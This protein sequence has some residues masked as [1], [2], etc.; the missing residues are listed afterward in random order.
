MRA[1]RSVNGR[2]AARDYLKVKIVSAAP[3]FE[4]VA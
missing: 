4:A 3:D 2:I 1:A